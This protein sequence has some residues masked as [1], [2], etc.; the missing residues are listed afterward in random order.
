MLITN[1]IFNEENLKELVEFYGDEVD[2]F[3]LVKSEVLL[4]NIYL[5]D[6]NIQLKNAIDILNK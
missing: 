3:D 5:D 2:N 4:L 1:L 6:S